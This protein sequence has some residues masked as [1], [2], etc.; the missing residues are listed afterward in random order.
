MGSL[1]SLHITQC[2]RSDCEPRGAHDHGTTHDK[3]SF[4]CISAQHALIYHMSIG[5]HH[6][7]TCSSS[8][9]ICKGDDV[10]HHGVLSLQSYGRISGFCIAI[11]FVRYFLC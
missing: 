7:G 3:A 8:A 2:W 10:R 1:N 5:M 11:V 9:S 6:H 4:R